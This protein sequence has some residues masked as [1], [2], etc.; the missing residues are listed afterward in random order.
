MINSCIAFKSNWGSH[1]YKNGKFDGKI[2]CHGSNWQYR[3]HDPV[4][5]KLFLNQN[6][7]H[8]EFKF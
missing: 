8:L 1:M 4:Y 2:I 5:S 7:I 3:Q 6:S